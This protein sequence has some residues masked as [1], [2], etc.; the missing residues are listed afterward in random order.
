[1]VREDTR[2]SD[3]RFPARPPWHA[4]EVRWEVEVRFEGEATPR[5]RF[6]VT[7]APP[8]TLR[9]DADEVTAELA[10]D[11]MARVATGDFLTEWVEDWGLP[12]ALDAASRPNPFATLSASNP[13]P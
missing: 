2:L 12:G 13:Y 8:P 3:A 5:H 10:Y 9:V 1:V 7:T 11:E 4:L 6:T